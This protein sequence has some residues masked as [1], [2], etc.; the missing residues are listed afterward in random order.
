MEIYFIK[1]YLIRI[2]TICIYRAILTKKKTIHV[3][4]KVILGIHVC[5]V[6]LSICVCIY[7][8]LNTNYHIV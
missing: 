5:T 3:F 7:S 4:F 6:V 8:V 2:D 1:R